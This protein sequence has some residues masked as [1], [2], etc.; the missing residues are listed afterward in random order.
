MESLSVK[1]GEHKAV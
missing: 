1:G